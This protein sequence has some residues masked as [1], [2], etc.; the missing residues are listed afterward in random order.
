MLS[1][2]P[3]TLKSFAALRAGALSRVAKLEQNETSDPRAQK[4][5]QDQ[6]LR[7]LVLH[8]SEHV[9]FWRRRFARYSIRPSEVR[10]LADL[11]ALPPLEDKDLVDFADE[12]LIGGT[13]DPA[14]HVVRA[15][16]EP[17]RRVSIDGEARRQRLADELRHVRWMGLDW[18][19]P[20]ALLSGRDEK[21]SALAGV[22]GRL[23]SSLRSGVWLQPALA[24]EDAVRRFVGEAA[25]CGAEALMG[26]PSALE[27]VADAIETGAAAR[28]KAP[29]RPRVVQSWGE[30]LTREI[31]ERLT[32]A[33][34]APVFDCYRTLALGELAHE[35]AERD[36]LHVSTDRVALEFVRDGAPVDD[37]DDGE[38]LVT[39]LDNFAMPMFRYRVGD[40]G[41]RFPARAMCACGRTSERMAVTDGRAS[42]LLTSPGGQR[43]HPDWFDWL[44]E[45]I[46]GVLDWRVCQESPAAL[47]VAIVPGAAWT[48]DAFTWIEG[49]LREI[50]P[51]FVVTLERV[52]ALPTRPDGRRVRVHS[53]APLAWSM[54][55]A[56][57]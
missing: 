14:W 48:D 27:R 56:T 5:E 19:T 50:D 4:A 41:C 2:L 49:A 46:P 39:P 32:T 12:L 16:D 57:A 28:G 30:C 25:A 11:A 33:L 10:A 24:D 34:G 37:G 44:F 36:G 17:R 6:K 1:I 47:T 53:T 54:A 52:D 22:S 45:E 31:R 13:P 26:N 15:L 23:R 40:V 7:A 20:R 29:F 18:R 35:C 21:G 3:R 42:A 55:G 51:A 43:V 9:P 8:A 38:I